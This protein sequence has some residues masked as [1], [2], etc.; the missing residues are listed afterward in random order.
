VAE[1][2]AFGSIDSWTAGATTGVGRSVDATANVG[3]AAGDSTATSDA[4][5]KDSVTATDKTAASELDEDEAGES[6][7]KGCRKNSW[8][9]MRSFGLRFSNRMMMSVH[10]ADRAMSAGILGCGHVEMNREQDRE[11]KHGKRLNTTETV[12]EQTWA[13]KER[14]KCQE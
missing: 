5:V 13:V 2:I 7:T 1:D 6:V 11:S 8:N 10:D 9:E 3:T 14:K 4:D 12:E